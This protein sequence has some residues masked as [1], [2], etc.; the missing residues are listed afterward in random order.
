[1][2]IAFRILPC[3][4]KIQKKSMRLK[5]KEKDVVTAVLDYLLWNHVMAWRNN[6]GAAKAE[7]TTKDGRHRDRIIRFGAAGS[8]D[9]IA[10]APPSGR[11][12]GIECK[13]EEGG[14]QS[15]LQKNFQERIETAGGVYTLARSI[16]DVVADFKNKI[17]V[18]RT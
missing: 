13:R 5:A 4:H 18:C 3:G 1:M 10:I 12:W 14:K 9:I 6:T 7:Y 8:P 2:G 17:K 16:D 11:F 15:A